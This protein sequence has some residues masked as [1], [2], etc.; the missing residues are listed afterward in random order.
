M[1]PLRPAIFLLIIFFPSSAPAVDVATL[2]K[3]VVRIIVTGT[4][5]SSTGFGSGSVVANGIVLTNE[6]V[7]EDARRVQVISKHTGSR[8]LDAQVLWASSDLD[9]AVLR[10][11]GLNLPAVTLA[12]G[13]PNK[14]DEV[15]SFGYPGASDFGYRNLDTTV[16]RGVISN[17]HQ[18]SWSGGR[19][20]RDSPIIQHD[21]TI[22][23][24][25][26]G[27]PLF[28]GCGRV[29]GVNTAGRSDYD[30]TYLASRI[31]EA[32]SNLERIGIGL[33]KSNDPCTPS[34]GGVVG[35]DEIAQQAEA[36]QQEAGTAL[37]EAGAAQQEAGT[38][39]QEA[40]AAQQ[41]AGTARQEAGTALQVA[42]T[43][44]QKAEEAERQATR[45]RYISLLTGLGVGLLALV[46][47]ALALRKPRRQII[48]GVEHIAR[49]SRG[50]LPSHSVAGKGGAAPVG[51]ASVGPAPVGPAP[52]G[53][54]PVGPAPVGPAPVG[55]APK[56]R[57]AL[58][59]AGFDTN[60]SK[61]RILV[62]EQG[63]SAA[64]G[65]YVIGRHAELVDQVVEN[66]DISR[67]HAR[68][69]VEH[70]QCQIEDMNSGNSTR[71]NGRLLDVFTPVP[72]SPG[73]KVSFGAFEMQ[74]SASY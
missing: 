13:Q 16:N 15:W 65:G 6:H 25:N 51:P 29:V 57:T 4:G 37:Q 58:V 10:V 56:G 73:D 43:A 31:T 14:G 67:R 60:G 70:G 11:D 62:P 21:A 59:L 52:V 23:S 26:S 5:S 66:P 63:T 68:I 12:T 42:G 36:A 8:L 33:Q 35:L 41:E 34:S 49:L 55:P 74:V 19:V 27:G 50:Y 45:T 28:D 38:A 3:S 9:L 20:S 18:T 1:L 39:R 48:Q 72:L 40:G 69:T 32:I 7:V 2:E 22:N 61:M 24:G 64:Q 54:A 47:I 44:Q 71:V 17:F 30:N 53:P 46:A